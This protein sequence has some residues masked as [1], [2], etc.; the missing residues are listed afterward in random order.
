MEPA[1][2]WLN[3]PTAISQVTATITRNL[4]DEA[5]GISHTISA[6][7]QPAN[8][9]FISTPKNPG[10]AALT[11]SSVKARTASG[12]NRCGMLAAAANS[13]V[14]TMLATNTSAQ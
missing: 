12:G 1:I 9:A 7:S 8:T 11:P 14:A 4:A 3:S 13:K 5:A 6:I 2:T 10:S